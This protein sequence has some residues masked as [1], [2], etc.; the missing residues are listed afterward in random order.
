M[1]VPVDLD[2]L[3][4]DLDGVLTLPGEP[5]W[6]QARQA[7]NLAV[8]QQPVAVA[9]VTSVR[10]VRTVVTAARRLGLRVA[11]QSTGHNA[12]PMGD[13]AGTILLRL[14]ELRGVTVDPSARVARAEGG[15]QWADVTSAAARHGLAALAGSSGDVGVAGYTLGGGVSWLGRSHGLALNHVRSFEVVTADG[16]VRRVDAEHHP[17]LFWALRGGGGSFAVVTAIEFA[18]FPIREV[19]AGALFFPLEQARD[20]LNAWARWTDTAPAEAMSI[21]RLIRFPVLPE[22]PPQL[23][24]QAY[25]V[26]E[27]ATTL[28][29]ASAD[30]LLAPLRAL[31]P[32]D[33]TFGTIPVD[34]LDQLNMDPPAPVPMYGDGWLQSE[35]N[36][37]AVDA[38][39]RVAGPGV[40]TPLLAIDLRHLGAAFT[41]G[42]GGGAVDGLPGTFLGF[43]LGITPEPE[44]TPPVRAAVTALL[45]ALA[46][47]RAQGRYLN[48]A[49]HPSD[50]SGFYDAH[51]WDRLRAVKT[52]YDPDDLIRS[53]HPI[54]VVST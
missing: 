28:D 21:G 6:D 20:V 35:L 2:L 50:V 43:V 25:A 3:A 5:G 44:S 31:G 52:A 53:N 37:E 29:P 26:V 39:V 40:D 1:S 22:L 36:T 49:E 41:P 46:P 54:P 27:V 18:L 32:V 4:L 24:G 38:I 13:L 34:Q 33:D 12:S 42:R 17:D 9:T 11:A 48:F 51:T 15:A 30:D 19:Y 8:D 10:D 7:W 16:A 47:W 23:S 45:Y 14:S